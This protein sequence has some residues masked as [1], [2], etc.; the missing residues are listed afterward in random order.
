M[1]WELGLELSKS[2]FART[3]AGVVDGCEVRIEGKKDGRLERVV[4]QGGP[5]FADLTIRPISTSAPFRGLQTSDE[6]FDARVFLM[7][8][9]AATLS[10]MHHEARAA[11][12]DVVVKG[13]A[14]VAHRQ[15]R[16]EEGSARVLRGRISGELDG[17]AV[18]KFVRRMLDLVRVL[19]NDAPI[20]E[21]LAHNVTS[22][23]RVAVR[24]KNFGLM[25]TYFG[26]DIETRRAARMLLAH[27]DYELRLDAATH[28]AAHDP[29]DLAHVEA[30]F[31]AKRAPT[32]VRLLAL[33]RLLT[34]LDADARIE[35]LTKVL[36]HED[37]ATR[38]HALDFARR[39]RLALP[40]A[41]VTY[42]FG[43][44]DA[45]TV[46]ATC[47][48]VAAVAQGQTPYEPQL[49]RTLRYQG[50]QAKLAA[51][52]A[53]GIAGGRDAVPELRRVLNGLVDAV[54]RT[55][56]EDALARIQSRLAHA[57]GGLSIAD[58]DKGAGAVSLTGE[59]GTLSLP[60]QK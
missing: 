13:G 33:T 46:A 48:W 6:G 57:P 29:S 59:T 22:D 8:P 23:E 24:R 32:R 60:G 2:F 16:L 56:A 37:G 10:L 3:L 17:K 31:H 11:T 41:I 42:L 14:T 45:E 20:V 58:E 54:L 19:S 55:K 30:I 4:V 43:R 7:G 47:R 9:E 36:R 49:F 38:L 44:D 34:A 53:L 50:L 15:V 1:A 25:T 28:L 21:R 52:E 35:T 51:A 26:D 18:A 12:V 40:D 27:F 5:T 39:H